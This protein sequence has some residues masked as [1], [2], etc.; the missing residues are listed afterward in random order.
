VSEVIPGGNAAA[1]GVQGGSR[2]EAVRYGR[3]VIYLGGDIITAVDGMAVSSIANLYEALE[4][5]RPGERVVVE[6]IRGRRRMEA[7]IVLSER[8][9][10]FQW[11]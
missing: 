10:R 5:N 4:D 2:S 6:F 7:E 8:P 1:A 9:E 11:D 3:T